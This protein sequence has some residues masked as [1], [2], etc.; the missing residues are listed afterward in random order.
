MQTYSRGV[1]TD[2]GRH[3][4]LLLSG[5]RTTPDDSSTL[6]ICSGQTKFRAGCS[7]S[8]DKIDVSMSLKVST[9]SPVLAQIL[10]VLARWTCTWYECIRPIIPLACVS[11][12]HPFGAGLLSSRCWSI[13]I[14]SD[15][16]ASAY[17]LVPVLALQRV[18]L[19]VS[20]DDSIGA[21]SGYETRA[22]EIR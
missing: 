1:L 17:S 14:H 6:R 16:G 20:A 7:S 9:A 22:V 21:A 11:T 4:R 18:D 13:Y 10:P 15:S 3:L 19:A 5:C 8:A 12:T 2:T